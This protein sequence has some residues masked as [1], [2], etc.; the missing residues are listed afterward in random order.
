MTIILRNT[1]VV[2]ISLPKR[3]AK[4]L[5]VVSKSK[6]QSRSAFIASLIDKEAENERW[7]YLLKLGRETGKKFNITSEDDIDRILHESS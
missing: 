6:G 7:K 2:S 4:K 5:R 3:I 1:E